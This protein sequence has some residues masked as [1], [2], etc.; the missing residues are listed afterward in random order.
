MTQDEELSK[1]MAL[2]EQYKEQIAQLEYQSSYIQAAI[3]DYNKAK[4]TIEQLKKTEKG[5]DLV[6]PIGGSTFINATAKDTD[7]VL[8]DI[9]SGIISEKKNDEAVKKIEQRIESLK[10][11]QDRITDSIEKIQTEATEISEK[12]QKLYSEQ[13]Q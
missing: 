6:V 8:I 2:I 9:G 10:K 11:T 4:I 12:A 5:I 13:L 7:K 1:Y 3:N